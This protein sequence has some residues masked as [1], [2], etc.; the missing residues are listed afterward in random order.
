MTTE[1]TST[2]P[3]DNQ[4]DAPQGG[5]S[6]VTFGRVYLLIGGLFGAVAFF[7]MEQYL[8]AVAVFLGVGVAPILLHAMFGQT[9]A[10][11]PQ[12]HRVAGFLD[13]VV[14]L[15]AG[16]LFGLI[17]ILGGRLA[18]LIFV[19]FITAIVVFFGLNGLLGLAGTEF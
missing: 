17:E 16:L 11:Q 18:S 8:I 7:R 14:K 19:C 5:I 12:L 9:L 2:T 1:P 3:A 4:D 10:A 13:G 15:I 6:S